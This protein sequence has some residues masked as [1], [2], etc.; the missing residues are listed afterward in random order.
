M[1]TFPDLLPMTLPRVL[2]DNDVLFDSGV[3]ALVEFSRAALSIPEDRELKESVE[4]IED[5]IASLENDVEC[6]GYLSSA[7]ESPAL[8]RPESHVQTLGYS[9]VTPKHS[10][11]SE[12]IRS[13]FP[14]AHSAL[15]E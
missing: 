8:D 14:D 1:L 5:L 9:S 3:E 2:K 15:I 10:H 7:I 12:I 11:Y 4:D 13:K 6:L